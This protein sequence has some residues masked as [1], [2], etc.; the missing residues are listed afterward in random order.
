MSEG[1]RAGRRT[2]AGLVGL[3]LLSGTVA[4]AQEDDAVTN[5]SAMPELTLSADACAVTLDDIAGGGF[6]RTCV[7]DNGALGFG[8]CPFVG[9]GRLGLRFD[10]DGAAGPLAESEDSNE[11]AFEE[12]WCV[13]YDGPA[14]NVSRC[15]AVFE[16]GM[17]GFI[18]ADTSTP[19][20]LQATGT[21]TTPDGLL[22]ADQVVTLTSGSHCL[23]FDIT[24][25]NVGG[26]TLS[27]VEYL[28]NHDPDL[29]LRLGV[30][31]GTDNQTIGR[32]LPP[33]PPPMIVASTVRDFLPVETRTVGLGTSD[34]LPGG[35]AADVSINLFGLIQRDPDAVLEG[36]GSV[37]RGPLFSDVGT[38]IAFRIPS[39]EPGQSEGLSFC[40]CF[41]SRT[42]DIDPASAAEDIVGAF[43]AD[44]GPDCPPIADAAGDVGPGM[45]GI[46]IVSTEVSDDGENLLVDLMLAGPIPRDGAVFRFHIDTDCDTEEIA[47]GTTTSDQTFQLVTKRGRLQFT[48]AD[49]AFTFDADGDGLDDAV[50]WEL[51]LPETELSG[52]PNPRE[53]CVFAATKF[54]S[55]PMSAA[56][57]APDLRA[58]NPTTKP[59]FQDE[60][61]AM[62]RAIRRSHFASVPAGVLIAVEEETA[63]ADS[64]GSTGFGSFSDLAQSDDGRLFGS[65]GFGGSGAIIRINPSTGESTFV[66]SSGFDALPAL[67]FGPA[68]TAFAGT[69]YGVGRRI[70]PAADFG[71]SDF[72]VTIDTVTGEATPV[73]ARSIGIPFID[74][75]VFADDGKLYGAGFSRGGQGVLVKINP[76]TGVGRIIGSMGIDFAAG[77][78]VAGDGTLLGSLGGFESTH[79][80][81][82]ND[83]GALVSIDPKTGK[84]TLIGL[85]GFAPVS[86]LTVLVPVEERAE[87][88]ATTNQGE[89]VEID[90]DFGTARLRGD[91]GIFNG[92]DLGWSGLSFDA[93][94]RLFVTSKRASESV[95]DGCI[96]FYAFGQ[97]SHLY[98]VDPGTG[99]VL[100]EVGSMGVSFVSDIDV[101]LDG[102]IFFPDGTLYGTYYV[103]ER[104][105][106]DGG[107]IVI[108]PGTALVARFGIYGNA[109]LDVDL[110]NG[111]LSV[112]PVTG[113]IWGVESSFSASP[114]LYR[115]DPDTGLAIDGSVV[116][117]GLNGFPTAFGLDSLEILPD[118]RFFGTRGRGSNELY[119][120][121]PV[122]GAAGLAGL[123]RVPLSFD[124]AVTGS[125]NGLEALPPEE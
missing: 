49:V 12:R 38:S 100:E 68:G 37:T 31:F 8:T 99:A 50:H 74:G 93:A 84:A 34:P 117:L 83:P 114:S 104:A 35:V 1:T 121:D 5:E 65:R 45:E 26:S 76:S 18:Q 3:L 111:G 88:L 98:R 113:E 92:K 118:G 54:E 123:R 125:L 86:G 46:D 124:P 112:H 43:T 13:E 73:G 7:G 91:A 122:P 14:G 61:C 69:L 109:S 101:S 32:P 89:L 36:F 66:G 80:G 17:P 87:I 82:D 4:T 62:T 55:K 57:H 85:T 22:R 15:N 10:P 53:I 27:S 105:A 95:T 23:S 96:G 60:I 40:Y 25:T 21:V 115:V 30:G 59:C 78:E 42:E 6:I 90:L 52:D 56:D 20:R 79:G 106:G 103:D 108:D 94:G 67:D 33:G 63:L 97:C 51:P 77:L 41:A 11:G 72:L 19:G 81:V 107:L 16:L 110:E 75:L 2:M 48:G 58:D 28:R 116:R 9:F 119:E 71:I 29:G 120:I 102:S 39:L 44:C 64:I 70:D 24:L 47:C